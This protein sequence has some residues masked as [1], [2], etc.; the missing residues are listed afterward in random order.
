MGSRLSAHLQNY[1][2][3]D[4]ETNTF[5]NSFLRSKREQVGQNLGQKKY[6]LNECIGFLFHLRRIKALI[7]IRSWNKLKYVELSNIVPPGSQFLL[8]FNTLWKFGAKFGAKSHFLNNK[9]TFSRV[10]FN[11][12]YLLSNTV[13]ACL[14]ASSAISMYGTIAL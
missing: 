2:A 3:L 10:P 12:F 11:F 9:G 14:F 4:K 8:I 5:D 13:I 6:T 1:N 7:Y